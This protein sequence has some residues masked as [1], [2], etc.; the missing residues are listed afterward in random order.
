MQRVAEV[1]LGECGES[2]AGDDPVGTACA[3]DDDTQRVLPALRE[4]TSGG[5]GGHVLLVVA[6]RC[7]GPV[8]LDVEVDDRVEAALAVRL[9]GV[10]DTLW[11]VVAAVS[12][13]ERKGGRLAEAV[14]LEAG[15]TA[16]GRLGGDAVDDLGVDAALHRPQ[17]QVDVGRRD[18]RV[19]CS[20]ESDVVVR[21]S[22]ENRFG[23][24]FDT[25]AVSDLDV[26]GVGRLEV[27]DGRAHEAAGVALREG[28]VDVSERLLALDRDRAF[29]VEPE[30]DEAEHTTAG[31]PGRLNRPSRKGNTNERIT[32]LSGRFRP[33]FA[34]PAE[35]ASSAR[36]HLWTTLFLCN[37]VVCRAVGISTELVGQ[38]T[39]VSRSTLDLPA[40]G[41][42]SL[43]LFVRATTGRVPARHA[44]HSHKPQ[45]SIGV[46][47]T[48]YRNRFTAI[49][50]MT[51]H[52]AP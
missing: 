49:N 10:D 5:V 30:A 33:H 21:G 46:V 38:L 34:M 14:V 7:A 20:E 51:A 19:A 39:A 37:C 24:L 17:A 25:R 22:V 3:G 1:T 41:Y 32:S 44:T 16:R 31:W 13:R 23:M 18:H 27:C 29:V 28:P 47:C 45:A 11:D 36:W 50:R 12:V 15:E 43:R 8:D 40:A 26:D 48:G 4:Q 6:V 2:V 52:K 35:V 42:I 9:D